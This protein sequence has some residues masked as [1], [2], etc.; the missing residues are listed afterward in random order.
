MTQK[1]HHKK[2]KTIFDNIQTCGFFA[3]KLRKIVSLYE[4]K[5]NR[6]AFLVLRLNKYE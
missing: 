1:R 5:M 2:N 4:E 6:S 3:Q